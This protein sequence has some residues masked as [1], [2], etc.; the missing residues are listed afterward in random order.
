ME[1]KYKKNYE[2]SE[3]DKIAKEIKNLKPEDLEK[4]FYIMQG[5]RIAEKSLKMAM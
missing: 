3:E 2:Q 4:M 1:K 5:M